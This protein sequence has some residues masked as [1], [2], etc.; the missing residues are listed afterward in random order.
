VQAVFAEMEGPVEL[1]FCLKI[2]YK[3]TALQPEEN[4]AR[5]DSEE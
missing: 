2:N 5:R 4:Q 1:S 3:E